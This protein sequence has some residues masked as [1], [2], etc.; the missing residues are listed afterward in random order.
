MRNDNK[1]EY[2]ADKFTDIDAARSNLRI[3]IQK[4]GNE[5][6]SLGID[7]SNYIT[8][9]LNEKIFFQI[10]DGIT[11]RL[12]ACIFHLDL[13]TMVDKPGNK[14]V[15]S[16]DGPNVDGF[17]MARHQG[18]IFDSI[19][20]HA[21]ST[22]DFCSSLIKYILE[23]DK[24][25]WRSTWKG[26]LTFLKKNQDTFVT[27]FYKKIISLDR[28]YINTL[29]EYRADGFHYT[30]DSAA[31]KQTDK[32]FEGV[33]E[34]YIYA[35]SNFYKRF[36]KKIIVD[37]DNVDI[38]RAALWVLTSIV[39]VV[40]EILTELRIFLKEN[41]RTVEGQEVFKIISSEEE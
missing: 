35:P 21:T 36:R 10:R 41:R 30:K 8:G 23:K 5:L 13:L 26:L 12:S 28:D 34:V 20:F 19:I 6:I 32:V 37:H 25:R 15:Y 16:F 27:T 33:T 24:N 7:Y 18:F 22:L 11:A 14:Y 9:T 38:I 29:V 1:F 3:E 40:D 2:K 4:L 31:F 39:K 17:Y